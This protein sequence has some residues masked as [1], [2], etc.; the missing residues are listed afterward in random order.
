MEFSE[1]VLPGHPDKFCDQVSDAFLDDIISNDKNAK[2]AVETFASATKIVVAGEVNTDYKFDGEKIVRKVLNEIGYKNYEPEIEIR[3][4]KQSPDIRQGVDLDSEIGAGDQGLMFG[5]ATNETDEFLPR[6]YV[7]TQKVSKKLYEVAKKYSLG[8]DGKNLVVFDGDKIKLVL[9]SIQ[10]PEEMSL[11]ELK[12][13]IGSE[14]IDK[15][16]VN[17]FPE[18][19][20]IN[21]TGRFVI[22]GPKGDAGLTGRKIIVDTYGGFARHGGGAFSG[23]DP[24]KVDRSAAYYARYVAKSLVA[25]GL[26]DK[27]EFGLA[28]AIGVPG[29]ISTEINCFGTEKK[30]IDEIKKV[31]DKNFN[32]DVKNMI[33]EL[34]L[35]RAIYKKNCIFGHFMHEDAPWEKVKKLD[36]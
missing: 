27:A 8:P 10:H 24:S 36:L 12:K 32:F 33:S 34:G 2:V 17:E 5:F 18:K 31:I 23:K 14:V 20:L 3:I 30:P 25:N 19:I 6:S 13:I 11:D 26:C 9:I 28:Y 1:S 7:Y 15:I 29:A 35:D 16:F 21:P 22:G 4:V